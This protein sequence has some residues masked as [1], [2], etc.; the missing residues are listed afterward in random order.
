MEASNYEEDSAEA[1]AYDA[2]RETWSMGD[3]EEE[4]LNDNVRN[5]K[6]KKNSSYY[7]ARTQRRKQKLEEEKKKLNTLL[8]N[9]LTKEWIK[10]YVQTNDEQREE[11]EKAQS[12]TNNGIQHIPITKKGAHF[13]IDHAEQISL[14][15][16]NHTLEKGKNKLAETS[17]EIK[18][19]THYR[20]IT[21]TLRKLKK[22]MQQP[23]GYMRY[24][25]LNRETQK[26][27]TNKQTQTD[28][29][30]KEKET[31]QCS[32]HTAVITD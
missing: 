27:F 29:D 30:H 25:I 5:D 31:Q 12:S 26:T 2:E 16:N 7:K 20:P 23:E 6:K 4:V 21:V 14:R 17:N 11:T 3:E 18:T 9:L 1:H 32:N 15:L 24:H 22:P 19:T 28:P 13:L 8:R 10:R